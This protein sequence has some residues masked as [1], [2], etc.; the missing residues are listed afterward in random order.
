MKSLDGLTSGKYK[1]TTAH[2]TYYIVD[3]DNSTFMR[4]KAEDRNTLNRDGKTVP[5]ISH[6]GINI[7][8]VIHFYMFPCHATG[9]DTWRTTTQVTSIEVL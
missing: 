5:F 1:V 4:V 9:G 6:D 3:L 8:E 2:K 7:G